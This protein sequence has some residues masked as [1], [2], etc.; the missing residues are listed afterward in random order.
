MVVV[1]VVDAIGVLVGCLDLKRAGMR[2]P[3]LSRVYGAPTSGALVV[4]WTRRALT[5]GLCV[6]VLAK[7]VVVVGL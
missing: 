2:P 6:V 3:A 5:R 7:L 1:V 4:A